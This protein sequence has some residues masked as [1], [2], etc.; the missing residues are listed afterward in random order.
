MLKPVHIIRPTQGSSERLELQV[1]IELVVGW[2]VACV[3]WWRTSMAVLCL[4]LGSKYSRH[5]I[6]I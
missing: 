3:P 1:R 6:W 2:F 4:W 5:A